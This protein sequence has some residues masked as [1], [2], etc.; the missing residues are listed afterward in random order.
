MC[1]AYSPNTEQANLNVL[2]IV[3]Y[4]QVVILDRH[5]HYN[6]TLHVEQTYIIHVI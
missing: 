5:Y 3:L 6:N 2:V 1:S 4:L